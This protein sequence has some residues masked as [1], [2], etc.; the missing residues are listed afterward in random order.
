[1][2]SMSNA[3]SHGRSVIEWG[4][5]GSALD[6]ESGDLHLVVP[7]E[8][9]AL[10]ALLDGLGHGPE[11]AAASNVAVPILQAHPSDSVLTLIQR[12]HE[13][14]RKTR[15][16]TMSL[17]SFDS[18]DSSMS[19]IGV[20]NVDCSLLRFSDR[21]EHRDEALALR[22]GVVGYRLPPVHAHTLPVSPGDTLIM[23]TDGIRSGFT[24]GVEFEHGPQEIAE[25]ILARFA[26]KSDDAHVVVARYL[27]GSV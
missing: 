26:K 22:G 8:Q 7:F 5:A 20:G 25:S 1:M 23:A 24:A 9:G 16:V 21:A 15:G 27:G 14:L 18:R 2:A 17:A 3:A 12:C 4:W 6:V 11:A 19:W 10:V 13:G